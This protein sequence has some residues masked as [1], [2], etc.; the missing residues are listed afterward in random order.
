VL[1]LVLC[2]TI[3]ARAAQDKTARFRAAADASTSR[4]WPRGNCGAF[5]NRLAMAKSSFPGWLNAHNTQESRGF[6]SSF[7]KYPGYPRKYR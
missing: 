4:P 1:I 7:M 6:A 3:S 5:P 2:P